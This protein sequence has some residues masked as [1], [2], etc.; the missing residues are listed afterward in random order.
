V[1]LQSAPL[2]TGDQEAAAGPVTGSQLRRHRSL[3]YF[4][5]AQSRAHFF[6]HVNG[7]PHVRHTLLSRSLGA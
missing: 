2:S 1:E 5:V 4:T 3:Q 7:S 6:R